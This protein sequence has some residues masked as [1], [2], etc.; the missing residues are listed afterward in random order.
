VIAMLNQDELR[1]KIEGVIEQSRTNADPDWY[2]EFLLSIYVAA[3]F[4]QHIT[5]DNV[6]DAFRV[7]GSELTTQNKMAA[8]AAMRNA[9]RLGWIE[10]IA[11]GVPANFLASN[12][13]AAGTTYWKSLVYEI[14]IPV[15]RAAALLKH[16]KPE[17]MT[18]F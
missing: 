10:R 1:K 16:S 5:I 11:G 14:E 13:N 6:W 12:H 4:C 3:T 2:R 7:R 9:A 15:S 17:Q 8:G 18:L